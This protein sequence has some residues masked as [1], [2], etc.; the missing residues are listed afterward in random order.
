VEQAEAVFDSIGLAVD[1][2]D[3]SRITSEYGKTARV[4]KP[5]KF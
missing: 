1:R 2:L 4:A 3:L 5:V